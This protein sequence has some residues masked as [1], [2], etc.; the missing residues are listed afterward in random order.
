MRVF[1]RYGGDEFAILLPGMG[2][3][4]AFIAAE[5]IRT[6]ILVSTNEELAV[7]NVSIGLVTVV[8]DRN[9]DM[10]QLYIESDKALYAAKANGK[11]CVYAMNLNTETEF[12]GVDS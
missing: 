1:G 9:T 10:N 11:N 3:D 12:S 8:P 7:Y 2:Q 6:T 5:M 4:E